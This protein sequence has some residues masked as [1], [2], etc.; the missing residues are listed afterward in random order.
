MPGQGNIDILCYCY[1]KVIQFSTV[2]SNDFMTVSADG[3]DL[4]NNELLSM[5]HFVHRH[6][7]ASS[8]CSLLPFRQCSCPLTQLFVYCL[9]SP[10]TTSSTSTD[11]FLCFALLHS[12][13]KMPSLG[14][15]T[16]ITARNPNP[17]PCVCVGGGGS[18]P[19]KIDKGT[20]SQTTLPQQRPDFT[21]N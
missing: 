1:K 3:F 9:L 18:P 6:Y 10:L 2:Y 20:T 19:L 5:Q 12:F 8:Q 15:A 11:V 4:E 13:A 14:H 21:H 17:L 7:V 16:N